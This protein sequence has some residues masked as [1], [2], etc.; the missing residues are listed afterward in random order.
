MNRHR[1]FVRG[2]ELDRSKC[3]IYIAVGT[4]DQ[5]LKHFRH[6]YKGFCTEPVALLMP[7]PYCTKRILSDL[8]CR[9]RLKILIYMEFAGYKRAARSKLPQTQFIDVEDREHEHP[10][11]GEGFPD[12]LY[13]GE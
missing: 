6:H 9:E 2:V 8:C 12:C 10:A 4:G 5:F 7:A 1:Y 13:A 11:F 3:P